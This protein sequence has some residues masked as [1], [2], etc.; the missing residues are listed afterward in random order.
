MEVLVLNVL[1]DELTLGSVAIL[2]H[3]LNNAAAI[4]LVAKLFVLVAH[5]L[6][7]LINQLVLLFVVHLALLHQ[8]ATVV[9]LKKTR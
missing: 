3:G 8:Q 7:A 2:N 1:D 5:E 6:N 4:V 9:Y